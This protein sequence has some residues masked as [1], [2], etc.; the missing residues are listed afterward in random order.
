MATMCIISVIHIP[1]DVLSACSTNRCTCMSSRIRILKAFSS[2]IKS[3]RRFYLSTRSCYGIS[4]FYNLL[5]FCFIIVTVRVTFKFIHLERFRLSAD[6]DL[7]NLKAFPCCD[8]Y[9][10]S[11]VL[12]ENEK[13]THHLARYRFHRP[14]F[15]ATLSQA[16]AVLECCNFLS[17]RFPSPVGK[18]LGQMTRGQV[19]WLALWVP[20]SRLGVFF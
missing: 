2:E 7:R 19:C 18:V 1:L 20:E 5:W 4:V 6:E 3:H 13:T 10:I 14:K 11:S 12:N 16:A 9:N 15:E 8:F 17:Y